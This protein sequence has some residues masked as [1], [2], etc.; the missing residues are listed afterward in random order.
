MRIRRR[1][2]VAGLLL[3]VMLPAATAIGTPQQSAQEQK[4]KQEDRRTYARTPKELI[5]YARAINPYRRFFL[6]PPAYRGPGRDEP[7]ARGLDSVRIGV[8]APLQ[9]TRDDALGASLLHGVELAVAEAN[10]DGGYGGVPFEVVAHNDQQLWGSSSNTL[11][12]FAYRDRVWALIGSIDSNSTHVALRAALKAE[13]PIVNVG[14]TDPTITETAIPWIIR[15]TPDDRQTGYRLARDL[16]EERGARHVAVVRASDRYGRLGI[17]EFRDAA[18]RLEHPLELEILFDPGTRDFDDV[19]E[20]IATS[21]VDA[22]VLWAGAE[23]AGRIVRQVRESGL[24]Q[25]IFGTDRLVSQAFL[26]TAGAAAQGIEAT[27]WMEPGRSD[28]VWAGFSRRFRDRFAVPP[29][30]WAAYAYDAATLTVDAIRRAGLNHARI[31][32][33]LGSV[34]QYRGVA[35]PMVF[36]TTWNNVAEP[37]IVRVVDGRFVLVTD[38][39]AV[40]AVP[41]GESLRV[42]VLAAADPEGDAFLVGAQAAARDVNAAGGVR[43]RPLELVRLATGDSPWRAGASLIARLASTDDLVGMIGA[44]DGATAHV[45]AQIAARR[46]LPFVSSSPEESL[47]RAGVPWVLRG[48]PSD[49]AQARAVLEAEPGTPGSGA[50]LV[51]PA[52]REGR[53]RLVALREACARDGVTVSAELVGAAGA[54]LPE[55]VDRVLLWLEPGPALE[56]LRSLDPAPGRRVLGSLRLARRRFLEEAA[57]LG[58]DVSVPV[59]DGDDD[60]QAELDD[61]ETR[62]G[63]DLLLIAVAA[64]DES[65]EHPERS[66]ADLRGTDTGIVG[67]RLWSF[68]SSGNRIAAMTVVTFPG[69]GHGKADDP[70]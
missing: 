48:V 36:D 17:R 49:A 35:G 50:A 3:M 9:G 61:P 44:R 1:L 15:T 60:P 37:L 38:E 64:V 58:H 40:D 14:S 52:G 43:G 68:D 4:S 29:D 57:A 31:M 5:P 42:G 66:L 7:D 63:H 33:A 16:F 23:D 69:R 34:R 53:E 28:P 24:E 51:V 19:I 21:T 41:D 62:L 70:S 26:D 56:F 47:T 30:T 54:R 10:A 25:P 18:R 6:L 39:D 11:V 2:P 8:L 46:R 13:L 27:A 20:R 22:I 59:L 12:R 45:A 55:S 32:D 65:P 67:G